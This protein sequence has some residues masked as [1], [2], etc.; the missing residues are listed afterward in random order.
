MT[1]LERLRKLLAQKFALRAEELAPDS[2][3]QSLGIDS[4]A[5]FELLF[6]IEEKFRVTIPHDKLGADTLQ[7][8]VAMIDKLLDQQR[9]QAA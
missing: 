9:P 3:L 8:L 7:D 4:L 1:T 6:E 2:T 5:A